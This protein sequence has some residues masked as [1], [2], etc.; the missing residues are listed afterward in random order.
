MGTHVKH[1]FVKSQFV[2]SSLRW[3]RSF[4]FKGTHAYGP[5]SSK[6]LEEAIEASIAVLAVFAWLAA[7]T[8]LP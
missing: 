4:S 5:H 7:M 8:L 1:L 3:F 2:G 6:K